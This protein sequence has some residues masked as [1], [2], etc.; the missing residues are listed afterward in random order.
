MKQRLCKLS[1]LIE[2]MFWINLHREF[3]AW[4]LACKKLVVAHH[5]TFACLGHHRTFRRKHFSIFQCRIWLSRSLS[6]E[7]IE[8]ESHTSSCQVFLD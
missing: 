5:D 4:H 2:I 1:V 8:G 3:L 7:Q 6:F